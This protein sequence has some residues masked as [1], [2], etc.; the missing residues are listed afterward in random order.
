MAYIRP[1]KI[2]GKT[3]FYRVETYTENGKV[4]QRVLEY[5]G[6]KIPDRYMHEY[7]KRGPRVAPENR[8]PH[9]AGPAIH[10]E[11]R[12]DLHGSKKTREVLSN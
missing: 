10:G 6:K 1:K 5:L 2:R 12:G 7:Q 11:T 4:K 9:S 8:D 3:Y